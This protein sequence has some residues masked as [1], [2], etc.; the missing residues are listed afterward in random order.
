MKR[1]RPA[2]GAGRAAAESVAAALRQEILTGQIPAGFPLRQ[3]ALAARFGVSH[4][5]VRE[6]LRELAAEG[7]VTIRRNRGSAVSELAPREAR[8]LLEIRSA[9]EAQ[10]LRWSMPFIDDGVIGRAREIV[11][12]MEHS[13]DPG[14]W[15]DLNW[16]FHFT[17][18]ERSDRPM[19]FTMLRQLNAQVER[20]IRLVQVTSGNRGQTEAEHRAILAACEVR[21]IDAACMLLTQHLTQTATELEHLLVTHRSVP[22]EAAAAPGASRQGFTA[23]EQIE[24]A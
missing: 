24:P 5:P 16:R 4:I 12:R 15:M 17:L 11:D 13:T 18:Y 19:L 1:T 9:L 7:L 6:A 3:D 8:Q 22:R 14:E 2:R 20:Y 21:N 10:G 23:N